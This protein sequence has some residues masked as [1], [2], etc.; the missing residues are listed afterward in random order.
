[1]NGNKILIIGGFSVKYCFVEKYKT[2]SRMSAP[3]KDEKQK[4][5]EAIKDYEKCI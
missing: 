2:L 5:C 4:W 3:K 1:M